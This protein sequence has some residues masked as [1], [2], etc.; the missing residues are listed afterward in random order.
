MGGA[1][2]GINH[3]FDAIA[4]V[5]D[6]LLPGD[7]MLGI[8]VV[9]R[10]GKGIEHPEEAALIADYNIGI[11][12]VDQKGGNAIYQFANVAMDQNTTL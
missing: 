11:V 12:I 1:V 7:M 2:V 10:L 6:V 8:G 3:Y 5:V 4:D 9:R